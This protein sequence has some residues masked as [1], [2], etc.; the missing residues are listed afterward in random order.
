MSIKDWA[1]EARDYMV[2]GI[3]YVCEKF[4]NRGPGTQSERDAQAYLKEE[5]GKYADGEVLMEDFVEHPR[6]F[7]G[8]IPFSAALGIIS[9]IFYW[10]APRSIV[11]PIIG[12]VLTLF[13][14]LMFLF[15]F[16]FYRDFV[17]FLFPK[18]VSRN[19]YAS[20]K[21]S[22]EVKQRIIFGGHV[23]AAEEWTY[24]YH[25]GLKVLASVIGG[26]VGGLF[27]V[28]FTNIALLIYTAVKGL[29]ESISGVWLA[30]G[31]IMLIAVPF[32]IAIMFFIN[33][34]RLVDGANDNLTAVYASM[35]VLKLMHDHDF[36]FEN[37]E[38]ACL[39]SGSEEAGLRGAKAFAKKHK[40]GLL[41]EVP[42]VFVA[43]DTMREIEQL[44]VY[45]TGCTGTVHS[46]EAVGDLIHEAG[47]ECGVD[48]P[49]AK[50]YPGAIDSD[51]FAMYGLEASG[52]CGVNHD[53]RKYYHTREDTPD[54]MDPD[55][56]ELSL[57]ICLAAA[58]I[59]DK[60]GI[61]KK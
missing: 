41:A 1:P 32:F 49:R 54:N 47:L 35:A 20:R 36:R 39:L 5:I 18:A 50:L 27:V 59:Y 53:P 25:G 26:S 22:G 19:V 43:M 28:L 61:S 8:F 15:E 60:K 46:S 33:W 48:M 31:I 3:T 6:A 4:K 17:D 21:P 40:D 7:M 34:G 58:E 45:T 42:T 2:N 24:S 30:L 13:A 23:D 51:G 12:L 37:T 55:C 11:F 38:V 56:I 44:Q 10:L 52:F 14:T 29:P 57:K 9:V 16:M